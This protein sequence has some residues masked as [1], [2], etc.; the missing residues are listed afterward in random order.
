MNFTSFRRPSTKVDQQTQCVLVELGG[1]RPRHQL[2]SQEDPYDIKRT[3][4]NVLRTCSLTTLC[5]NWRA[6]L[7]D[8]WT[9][10]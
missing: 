3:M 4:L 8:S 10:E 5:R 6:G 2:R 9:R 7:S 1:R